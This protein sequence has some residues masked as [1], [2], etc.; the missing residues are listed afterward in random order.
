M[1]L[2]SE[3]TQT[4]PALSSAIVGV[5]N[6]SFPCGSAQNP[7]TKEEW[8][9]WKKNK[10]PEEDWKDFLSLPHDTYWTYQASK[11]VSEQ[12]PG[13]IQKIIN[14]RKNKIKEAHAKGIPPP[15][16]RKNTIPLI[17][18]S[19]NKTSTQSSVSSYDTTEVDDEIDDRF[20]ASN[21]NYSPKHNDVTSSFNTDS[22]EVNSDDDV[23]ELPNVA[24]RTINSSKSSRIPIKQLVTSSNAIE[25]DNSETNSDN[26]KSELPT[27]ITP[28]KMRFPKPS[29]TSTRLSLSTSNAIEANN[30]EINNDNNSSELS[31]SCKMKSSKSS[32]CSTRLSASS[33]ETIN[34]P[35]SPVAQNGNNT[36]NY[37]KKEYYEEKEKQLGRILREF[38]RNGSQQKVTN[39]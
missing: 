37:L 11:Y 36:G 39:R 16:K 32:R 26:D 31:S 2:T 7:I 34:Q 12:S 5:V 28:R 13:K 1:A 21:E 18:R 25:V 17:S 10:R 27:T 20:T 9:Q 33:S 8:K 15:P 30:S 35:L 4:L 6:T 3:S 24:S 38:P 22:Y 29:K 14:E 23:F 19:K